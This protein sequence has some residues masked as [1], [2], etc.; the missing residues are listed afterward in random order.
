MGE[1]GL[2]GLRYPEEYGGQDGDYFS[3]IVLAEEMARCGSGGVGMAISVQTEMA[4][5][6]IFKFGT[7]EQKQRY[8]V[9]AIAGTKIAALGITEPDGG[10]D[11]AN[12]RTRAEKVNGGWR[13]NGAK[14]FITNG[15]RCDFV[16]LVCRTG[17]QED[18]S[19]AIT[20]FLVDKDLPGFQVAR[21]LKKMGMHAS[22]TAELAFTNVE[23]SDD[24]VLGEV[25]RGF[26][27][28]MW[29]LQGERLIGAAGA[30]AGAEAAFDETLRWCQEREA[31]GRKIAGFQVT[32]HKLVDMYTEIQIAKTYVY[33]LAERWDR[34]DYP[35]A[36]ISM[37]KLFVGQVASRV[38][39]GCLQLFGGAGYMDDVHIS[40]H[41][42]DSRLIRIGAGTD[43]I[44]KEIIAKTALG[45]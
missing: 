45:L 11:V 12:V 35:V 19:G 6:P 39:D 40:R 29:E 21:K 23:V 25:N 20:L 41:Y 18:G 43:E 37:A 9:P 30:I 16:V 36:E 28:L 27:Q 15:V 2:L 10:S 3:A 17:K 31:F 26:Y 32:R 33:S 1:L 22:D 13:I 5:P 8:L 44:M 34:D 38:A 24:A 42:R 4:T 7:E 14:T